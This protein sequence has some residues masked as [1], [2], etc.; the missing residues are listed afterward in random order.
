MKQLLYLLTFTILL[1]TTASCESTLDNDD[2]TIENESSTIKESSSLNGDWMV[3]A[4]LDKEN[5]FGPFDIQ[6]Q[7]TSNNDSISIKDNG[8]FWNFQVKAATNYSNDT[9]KSDLSVNELSDVG[10]KIKV[11]NGKVDENDNINFEIQFEDDETPFGITYYMK[12][13]R[14]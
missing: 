1:F 9:F 3:K 12:G 6:I 7:M 10:A 14:K 2:F 11:L 4:Y 8:D 5:A 13:I